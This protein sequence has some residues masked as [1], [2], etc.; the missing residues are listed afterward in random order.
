[1]SHLLHPGFA[2]AQKYRV[3]KDAWIYG[4][5]F[6]A[7]EI[8]ELNEKQ[9]KYELMSETIEPYE[10]LPEEFRVESEDDE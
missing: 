7:G 6:K 5:F 10:P 8:V 1:M 4:K 9:A 3:V 2:P